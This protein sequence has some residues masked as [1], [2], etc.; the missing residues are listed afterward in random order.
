MVMMLVIMTMMIT[1][2]NIYCTLNLCYTVQYIHIYPYILLTEGVDI[3]IIY[4]FTDKE[5]EAQ[6]YETICQR[7]VSVRK[8]WNSN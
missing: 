5:I 3:K 2:N 6:K 1:E 7:S 4:Y 8:S